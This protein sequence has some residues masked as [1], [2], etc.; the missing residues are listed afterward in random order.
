MNWHKTNLALIIILVVIDIFLAVMLWETYRST[1]F[2]PESLIDGA[3]ENLSQ[4][5]IILDKDMIDRNLYTKPVYLYSPGSAFAEKMKTSASET[6][7]YLISV[8]AYLTDQTENSA[9]DSMQYFDI[10]DG[11]SISVFDKNGTPAASAVISGDLNFE[12]CDSG[13]DKTLISSE[14]SDLLEAEYINSEKTDCPDQIKKLTR[15][16]YDD[17]LSVNAIKINDFKD[18]KLV[19]CM[20]SVNGIDILDMKICFY[21]KDEKILYING[22]FLFSK[23]VEEYSAALIDGINILYNITNESDETINILSQNLA[24]SVFDIENGSKYI[25]PCWI[26]SYASSRNNPSNV[27][28]M[29]FNALT[30]ESLG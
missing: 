11:T 26:I 12:Y 3:T 28:Y 7:P 22:D 6:H 2:I 17:T 25:V 4:K 20:I 21:I 19:L 13:F 23:P 27:D 9:E 24:Y 15:A 18:G 5:N 1:R 14:V 30:G 29:I 8:L 16:V 10:P